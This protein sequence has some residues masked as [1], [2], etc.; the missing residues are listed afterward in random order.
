MPQTETFE[1]AVDDLTT[2]EAEMERKEQWLAIEVERVRAM[3]KEVTDRVAKAKSAAEDPILKSALSAIAV[4]QV[5]VR[6][7]VD[8]AR[9]ARLKA[10]AMRKAC[11]EKSRDLLC[12]HEI[13]L[14]TLSKQVRDE[15]AAAKTRAVQKPAPAVMAATVIAKPKPAPATVPEMAKV[16]EDSLEAS[17]TQAL[18]KQP[19][20]ED[21]RRQASRARLCTEISLGSDSNLFTGF[22][23]DVSEGGV[24]VATVNL[25]PLGS[26]VDVSFSLPGGA[27]VEAKGEVRWVR[28]LDERQPDVFP[29]MGIQ[30][31]DIPM[32]ALSAIKSFANDREPMF[33]PD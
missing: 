1:P 6:T 26:H 2:A 31:V 14:E 32:P 4:P 10:L 23:N 21:N 8:E 9:L 16:A 19:V 33:Y 18:D 27:K 30:F 29:G 24:F 11:M 13:E 28:V 17:L 15:E 7:Q 20:P 25:M 3:R 5:S 22:T 12:T